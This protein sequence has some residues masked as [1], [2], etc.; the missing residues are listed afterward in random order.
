MRKFL[1]YLIFIF[2]A[3]PVFGQLIGADKHKIRINLGWAHQFQFAGYYAALEKGYFLEE[4][5]EVEF[6]AAPGEDNIEKVIDGTFDYCVATGGVILHDDLYDKVSVVAAIYQQSPVS[7]L[8]LKSGNISTLLDIEGA[9]ILGA[10]EIKAMLVSAGLDLSKVNFHGKYGDFSGLINGRVDATSFFITDQALLLGSDSLLF[11]IWRPIE[12]GINFYG[13][14]L[15]TSRA[16]ALSRPDRV[17]KVKR[18]V[19]KGWQYAIDHPEEIIDIIVS[20]YNTEIDR[21]VLEKESNIIIHNLILPRFYDIGDMQ[22]S[23]WNEMA[24]ILYDF[25]LVD[26]PRDLSGFIYESEPALAKPLKIIIWIALL[27]III[28]AG[29]L[30]FL[31][32]YNRQLRNAV[33]VRTESLEKANQELDRFV[34]S[35][36]HDIRSPLSSVQGIINVM[37]LDPNDHEKYLE[38]IE[39][40]VLK[41]DNYTRDILDY[42]RNS[43]VKVEPKSVQIDELIE[44]CISQVRYMTDNNSL[45]ITKETDLDSPIVIDPWRLEVILTNIIGNAIKYRDTKKSKGWIKISASESNGI[46]NL[47]IEDNGIGI[48]KIHHEKIFEMFYRASEDSQGSGL[49]LYIVKE[50]VALLGGQISID[51]EKYKGTKFSISIPL[52]R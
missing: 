31:F 21:H 26:E 37:R 35:I 52:K 14:C 39:S 48:E 34:Y 33:K 22:M 13:D 20:K 24:K 27:A 47:S 16:E 1:T 25:G 49:G 4:G 42:T 51:S 5:F 3:S 2:L 6:I 18:A 41:L 9:N 28:S 32:F 36:S 50:T 15:F 30:F 40:S 17:E 38:L 23:R 44:K 12:Y 29:F 43:R 19:I 10:T 8:T 7:L 45:E 11:Q 46:L